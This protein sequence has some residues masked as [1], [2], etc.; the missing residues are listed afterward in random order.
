MAVIKRNTRSP[1]TQE[2]PLTI[3]RVALYACVS[4]LN[5]QRFLYS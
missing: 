4:T 5:G 2:V 1:R 3:N